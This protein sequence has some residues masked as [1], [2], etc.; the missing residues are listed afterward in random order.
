[1]S[2]YNILV[3]IFLAFNLHLQA[4]DIDSL[5][6]NKNYLLAEKVIIN[7][8]EI[9]P[10]N[11]SLI[12]KLGD[13]YGYMKDWDNAIV[14]YRKLVELK[15]NNSIYNYK[16]GGTLAA[17]ANDVNRFK[18]L[19]LI[20]EAKKYLIK[21]VELDNNNKEALWVLIQI[22]TELPQFLG[23][24]K[25]VALEY[26][27][28]LEQISL[29]DGL[30]SKKYI[31]EFKNDEKTA[32]TYINKLIK[33]LNSFNNKYDYNYLNLSI[34]E[35]CYNNKVELDKGIS[36]LGLYIKNYTSRDRT[37]PD[38]AY[39]LL[40]KIYFYKNDVY[41]AK[42]HL[43]NAIV[44]YNINEIQNNSLYRQMMKFKDNIEK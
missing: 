10:D 31:Y 4:Q 16:L 44:Y 8:I 40:S 2:F 41:T 39:Y 27:N 14:Q 1:M 28:D 21:S 38:Y 18:S 35:L 43:D 20:N 37:S 19:G 7:S 12:K 15:N 13:C 33:N 22:F 9:E 6:A 36:H 11:E 34:G 29:I 3:S 26:A 23:G 30:F 24:S 5:I 17:K 25:S 42:K 32:N